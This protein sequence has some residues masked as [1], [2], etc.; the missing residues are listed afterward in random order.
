[1]KGVAS[2]L[3]YHKENN[4]GNFTAFK[5]PKDKD[6]AIIRILQEPET[7]DGVFIHAEFQKT[8]PTRCKATYDDKGVEDRGTCPL[9]LNQVD[10][11][12]RTLIVVG[13]RGQ[14]IESA[15]QVVEY[16]RDALQEVI[17]QLSNLPPNVTATMIDFKVQRFGKDKETTYKWFPMHATIRPMT[18]GERALPIPPLEDMYPIIDD[19]KMLDRAKKSIQAGQITAVESSTNGNG[20]VAAAT[21]PTGANIF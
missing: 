18:E 5:L 19:Y 20:H 4:A 9:C 11:S 13:R 8:M 14:P 7:W 10:R 16:G 3:N 21:P 17:A 12:L 1:M 2:I 15:V 6:D